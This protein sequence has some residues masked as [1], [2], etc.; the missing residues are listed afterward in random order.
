[1]GDIAALVD[2]TEV[3]QGAI[4]DMCEVL[5]GPDSRLEVLH[6]RIFASD[7]NPQLGYVGLTS[8]DGESIANMLTQN[9]SILDLKI[10]TAQTHG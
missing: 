8:A 2:D 4:R 3:G 6:L 7:N 9:R 1:M 10:C 5:S